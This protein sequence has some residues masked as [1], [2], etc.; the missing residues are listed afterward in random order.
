MATVDAQNFH[1]F[2]GH[3]EEGTIV[4]FSNGSRGVITNNIGGWRLK[5]PAGEVDCGHSAAEVTAAI[6]AYDNQFA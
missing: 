5:H 3:C 4:I 6:L 1:P 2:A